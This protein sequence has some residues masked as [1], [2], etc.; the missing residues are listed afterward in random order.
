M[1]KINLLP[2]EKRK[3]ERTPLPRFL[4]IAS[5]AAAFFILLFYNLWILKR[6]SDTV[7]ATKEQ[8]NIL[9]SLKPKVDE[10]ERLSAEETALKNKVKEIE[11]LITRDVEYW[12]MVNALWDVIHSNPKVWIDDFRVLDARTAPGELR[13]VDPESKDAVA[14]AVTMRCHVAGDDVN[15][16]TKFR[17]ALKDHPLLQE[18]LTLINFNVMWNVTEEKMKEVEE[19]HAIDF[20]IAMFGLATPPKRQTTPAPAPP[21]AGSATPIKATPAPAPAQGGT[22]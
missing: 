18:I 20:D 19:S 17:K 6:I 21:K 10:F 7:D 13:R 16:M 2:T 15:E 22:K 4:L 8:N 1:I 5:T 11:S 3:A 9:V 12:R 14:Y